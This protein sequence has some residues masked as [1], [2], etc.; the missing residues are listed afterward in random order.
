MLASLIEI[1]NHN[2]FQKE[3]NFQILR[4]FLKFNTF[5]PVVFENLEFK[6]F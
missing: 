5:Y 6:I 3:N 2:I 4:R 1:E